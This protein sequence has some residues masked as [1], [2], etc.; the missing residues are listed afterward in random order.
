[1]G[2]KYEKK[3][4]EVIEKAK[5][6]TLALAKDWKISCPVTKSKESKSATP[7]F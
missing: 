3:K 7:G 6:G 4:D 1:M 2:C 5:E